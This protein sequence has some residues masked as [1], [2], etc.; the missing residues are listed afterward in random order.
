MSSGSRVKDRIGNFFDGTF[1]D[2]VNV[3]VMRSTVC[4]VREFAAITAFFGILS[5]VLR[6][7]SSRSIAACELESFSRTRTKE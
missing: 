4:D 1:N 3:D 5:V 7:L 6:L 2:F